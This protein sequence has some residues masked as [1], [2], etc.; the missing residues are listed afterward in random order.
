[1]NAPTPRPVGVVHVPVNID[2]NPY[3]RL[4]YGHLAAFGFE[5]R[6]GGKLTLLWLLR[7]RRRAS[8]LHFHWDPRTGKKRRGPLRNVRAW[9]EVTRTAIA[10]LAARAL[11]YRILWTIHEVRRHETESARLDRLYGMLLGRASHVLLAHDRQTADRAEADLRIP[12]RR[13]EVVPHGSYVGFYP[14]GRT[15]EE[16][17]AELGIASEA[18]AFLCFGQIRGYKDIELVLEAFAALERPDVALVVAG[19]PW[20]QWLRAGIEAAAG[21]DRR[22]VTLLRFLPEE[23]VAELYGACD[24]AV[25]ARR[26]GWTS[27]SVVLAL[28]LGVPVVAARLPAYEELLGGDSV[29][30]LFTPGDAGSLSV[31]LA[32]AARDPDS[33]TRKAAA[34]LRQAGQLSWTET[35]ART[36]ALLRRA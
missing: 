13:I 20:E 9:A 3:A 5:R 24:A 25:V 6:G 22:I 7:S 4:F 27:G 19:R 12:A 33:A 30:W 11:R 34:A 35:A 32:E 16:V 18:F 1:M 10:L 17:R 21:R 31:T 28:S 29:G 15:R 2:E 14:P 8:V 26:D 23:R 36:A